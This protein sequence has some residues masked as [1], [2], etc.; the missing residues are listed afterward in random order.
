MQNIFILNSLLNF[1]LNSQRLK[2]LWVKFKTTKFLIKVVKLLYSTK[3]I[4]GYTIKDGIFIIFLKYY[5]MQPLIKSYTMFSKPN[6]KLLL[7]KNKLINLKKKKSSI[8]FF[9][10]LIYKIYIF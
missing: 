2:K 7:T 1:I 6:K 5:Y 9:F 10:L 4:L 3:L 8:F